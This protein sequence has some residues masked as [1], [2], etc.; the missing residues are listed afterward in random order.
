MAR[1]RRNVALAAILGLLLGAAWLRSAPT[2][3]ATQAPPNVVLILVDDMRWDYLRCL[4]NVQHE[5]V[6][7]GVT[8]RN[9]FVE[10]PMCCPS[11][12]SF[13]TGN[14]SHTT[15]VFT[16]ARPTAGT[17]RS[18][19]AAARPRRSRPGSTTPGTTRAWSGST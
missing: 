5:L 2:V 6:A 13:L 1:P 16:N 12:V 9:A 3:A 8:F 14:D 18:T 4:P 17:R 19:T 15:G 7:P 10:N 11:R